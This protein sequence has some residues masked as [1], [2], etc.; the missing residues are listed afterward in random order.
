MG[1]HRKGMGERRKGMGE[2]RKRMGEHR[3]SI[4]EQRADKNKESRNSDLSRLNAALLY[5]AEGWPVV[6]LHSKAMSGACTCGNA[7]CDKPGMHPR[8]GHGVRDATTNRALIEKYWD[9]WPNAK[10]GIATGVDAGIIA[11]VIDGE[12]GRSKLKE[13]EAR[14]T[15]LPKTVT[16]RAPKE[17]TYLLEIGDTRLHCPTKRL[18]DGITILG[19]GEFVVAPYSIHDPELVRRFADEGAAGDVEMATAPQ[20]LMNLIGEPT[21]TGAQSAPSV[22]LV[23]TS[24]IVPEKVEWLWQ[25]FIA[26]GRLTGLVGYPGLGKSQV[27]IDLAAIVSTGRDFPGG[28]SNREAGHVIILAAEDHLADTIVP[29]L[30]AA[31][32][33]QDRV[34]VVKAVKEGDSER[35]F[36]L[37]ADLVRLEREHD[38]R[39]VKL[40][41]IDPVS[42][43]LGSANRNAGRDVRTI[44]DRVAS[45]AAKHKLAVLTVSHLNKSSGAS[46]ITR[47]MGSTE[48]VAVPRAVFLVTEEAGTSRRLFLP[49]KNNLAPDRVGYAFRIEDRIVAGGIKTSAVVW[50]DDPVTISADEALAAKNKKASSTAMDFLQQLLRDGPVDQTEAVRLGAEAGFTEKSLRTARENLGVKPTKEGFGAVGKWVWKL[51]GGLKLVVDN[52]ANKPAPP[53]NKQRAGSTG[54]SGDNQAPEHAQDAGTTEPGKPEGGPDSPDGGNAA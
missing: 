24:D 16:I 9:K 26:S 29:R 12:I 27:G 53:D 48:W 15:Q 37:S 32:A 46:A 33:D 22:I 25:G 4:G 8:T 11:V 50:D 6:P 38:L 41:V 19:D 30:I 18:A 28:A 23:R 54:G 35:P 2:H 1:E 42:S 7:D 21:S 20:W 39:R 3:K 47:I 34:H 44:L 40:V 5:A 13:L 51:P 31:G 10:I 49:L 14:N 45:F 36:N 43:Y 17:R 52:D